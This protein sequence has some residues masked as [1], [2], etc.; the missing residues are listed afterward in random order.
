MIK[1]QLTIAA[2]AAITLLGA[3][4]ASNGKLGS[5]DPYCWD[6]NQGI[7][8]DPRDWFNGD[9][10]DCRQTNYQQ[11]NWAGSPKYSSLYSLYVKEEGKTSYIPGEWITVVVKVNRYPFKYRGLV[12][13]ASSA[14]DRFVGE[15]RA[16]G[17]DLEQKMFFNP[18]PEKECIM[19]A[20]GDLKP[21]VS[22]F[23]FK[24]PPAGTGKVTFGC[25]L[26]IGPA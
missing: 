13:H 11:M 23:R 20:Q 8:C 22:E 2:F 19:H 5:G 1:K 17:N 12:L 26:K 14:T 16:A 4:A 18:T 21:L 25:L 10:L 15:W 7:G 6:T 3:D 9:H 24:A